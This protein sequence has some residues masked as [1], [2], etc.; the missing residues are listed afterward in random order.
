MLKFRV[1]N[2]VTKRWHWRDVSE[3]EGG[4]SLPEGAVWVFVY[5]NA[6]AADDGQGSDGDI[7]LLLDSG[8][9]VQKTGASW[10]A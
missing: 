5:A 4:D 8:T 9:F 10:A 2:D 1:F 6:A 7:A 3:S